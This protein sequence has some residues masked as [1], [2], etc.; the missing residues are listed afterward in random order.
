M[1]RDAQRSGRRYKTYSAA[2][3]AHAASSFACR[4]RLRTRKCMQRW[5]KGLL[6]W[7]IEAERYLAAC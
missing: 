5:E 2:C 3:W 4:Y 6:L 1:F 7:G